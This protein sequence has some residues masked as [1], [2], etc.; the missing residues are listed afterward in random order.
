MFLSEFLFV[1]G[2]WCSLCEESAEGL[3]RDV[4]F[5]GCFGCCGSAHCSQRL[6]FREE[7]WAVRWA[8]LFAKKEPTRSGKLWVLSMMLTTACFLPRGKVS[9]KWKISC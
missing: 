3:G 2:G 6:E 1:D 8:L 9:T 7:M 4:T 5:S